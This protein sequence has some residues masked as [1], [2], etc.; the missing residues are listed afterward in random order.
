LKLDHYRVVLLREQF[1]RRHRRVVVQVGERD[2]QRLARERRGQFRDAPAE[3][4]RLVV[5]EPAEA[6]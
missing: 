6:V 1:Q 2:H 5:A 3:V 4:R